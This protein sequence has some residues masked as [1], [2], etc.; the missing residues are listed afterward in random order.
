MFPTSRAL[1]VLVRASKA[2]S[3]SLRRSISTKGGWS[4]PV[5]NQGNRTFGKMKGL[6]DVLRPEAS[7]QSE[8]QAME[9]E[10][11]CR[12]DTIVTW[13]DLIHRPELLTY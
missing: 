13:K 9:D 4:W 12:E 8:T 3:W 1:P 2:C 11:T 10:A 7:A 5:V 6:Q